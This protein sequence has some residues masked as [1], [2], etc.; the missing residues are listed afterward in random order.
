[1]LF[2][3]ARKKVPVL[4]E[5]IR[6]IYID[7]NAG[8]HFPAG[9]GQSAGIIGIFA[10]R[11]TMN[12]KK[13]N[14]IFLAAIISSGIYLFWRIFFTLP[15]QEGVVSVAAGCALVLAETVTL[16]GTA[17]LMISRMRAPAFEIPFPEKTEPE[18]FPH[19]DVLIATHNEPEELLYKTVNACTFLEYPDPAKVHVYVCDD[20]GGRENIRRMAEHLGRAISA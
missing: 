20:D 4:T 8:S 19:V 10:G 9:A 18:S 7:H 13:R 1:M 14:R 16:S 17:E 5:E 6:T 15:L 2:A 11:E 3:C 12:D